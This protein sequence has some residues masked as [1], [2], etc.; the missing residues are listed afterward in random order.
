[1][2]KTQLDKSIEGFMNVTAKTT[3]AVVIPLYG[4]W[5]DIP[6]N[7]VNGKVLELIMSRVYSNIHQLYLIFVAH[8]QSL[9][10]DAMDPTSVANQLLKFTRMGNTHLVP[11]SRD[12]TYSEYII[13]GMEYALTETKSQFVVFLN[14]WTM[15]QDGAIDELVDRTNRA[16]DAKVVSG[17][18]LRSLIDPEDFDSYRNY[19]PTEEWD[20]SF[21]FCAIPRFVAESIRLDPRYTTH[22]ILERDVWQQVRNMQFVVISSQKIP[23]FPFDFPWNDYEPK[24]AFDADTEIFSS[25]WRFGPGV[26]YS[27]TRGAGRADKGR[28]REV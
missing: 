21:N 3:I 6:D 10:N 18:D 1:M 23:M 20:F 13:E 26:S 16:D 14:P 25:K 4:Y 11:V 27:D 15:I 28:P 5:G 19:T 2:E 8:P 22:A 9:P 12:A 24:E 7:P 17:Y